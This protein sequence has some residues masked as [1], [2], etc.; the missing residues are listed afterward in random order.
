MLRKGKRERKRHFRY[1]KWLFPLL[2]SAMPTLASPLATALK[3]HATAQLQAY[4]QRHHWPDYSSTITPWLPSTAQHLPQ[5]QQA[6]SFTSEQRRRQPWGRI[7]YQVS[8]AQPEWQIR[9]RVR[10]QVTLPVWVA[11][12]NILNG[13]SL[14][15]SDVQQQPVRIDKLFYGFYTERTQLVGKAAR[16]RMRSGQ[17]IT[18][19]LV[20]A[21]TLVSRNDHVV[22]K[23][24]GNGVSASMAGTALEDGAKGQSIRVRNNSSGKEITAWVVARGIVETT[25]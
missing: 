1:W 3:D 7:P 21:P 22:I 6:L 5:C 9:G 24:A 19:A 23:V 12:H 11:K 8:C 16:R 2:I 25:Y 17:V 4:A 15:A 10:V 13:Q 14:A 18:P 20:T